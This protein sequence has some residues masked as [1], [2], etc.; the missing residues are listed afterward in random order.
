VTTRRVFHT[1][2]R[3][4]TLTSIA[5]RYRVSVEDIKRWNGVSQATAGRKLALEVRSPAK[6]KPRA[7]ATAKKRRTAA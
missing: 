3:G 1:V 2:K 5:N 7:K 4:E 6:G